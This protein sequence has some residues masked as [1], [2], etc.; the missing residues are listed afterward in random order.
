MKI[1]VELSMT[2]RQVK[3]V[4]V[5]VP[6]DFHAWTSSKQR[7]LLSEVFAAD[8]GDDFVDADDPG[9]EEGWHHILST[10]TSLKPDYECTVDPDGIIQVERVEE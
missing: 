7:N 3:K 4:V 5:Q 9:C 8:E 2:V 1:R 10:T 6:D